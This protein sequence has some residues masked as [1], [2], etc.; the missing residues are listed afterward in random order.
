MKVA[1]AFGVFSATYAVL[2]ALSFPYNLQLFMYYPAL[3]EFHLAAQPPTSGPPINWYGWMA[4]A[5]IGG[6]I[7]GAISLA[8]PERWAAKVWSGWAWLIPAGAMAF[9]TY[10]ARAWFI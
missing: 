3:E 10:L 1:R 4:T 8:I 2:Y 5:A 9:L 6:I 7:A